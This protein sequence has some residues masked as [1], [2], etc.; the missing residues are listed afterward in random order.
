MLVKQHSTTWTLIHQGESGLLLNEIAECTRFTRNNLKEVFRFFLSGNM[1]LRL[2]RTEVL[3]TAV[4]YICGPFLF[5]I[6]TNHAKWL[7]IFTIELIF[8]HQFRSARRVYD[9]NSGKQT[10]NYKGTPRDDGTLVR[11]SAPRKPFMMFP[12]VSLDKDILP[13]NESYMKT[14]WKI[15]A[16]EKIAIDEKLQNWTVTSNV[17]SRRTFKRFVDNRHVI[18]ALFVKDSFKAKKIAKYKFIERKKRVKQ[19][20]VSRKTTRKVKFLTSI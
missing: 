18:L 19:V 8:V 13:R 14:S 3:G 20:A 12:C 5:S 1:L 10:R 15:L 4:F 16:G 9:V 7:I 11:V 17:Q 2:V 6:M